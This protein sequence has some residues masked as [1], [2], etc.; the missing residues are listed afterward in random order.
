MKTATLQASETS[1]LSIIVLERGSAWPADLGKWRQSSSDVII[2]AQD[3]QEDAVS[4]ARRVQGRLVVLERDGKPVSRAVVAVSS[5][6]GAAELEA[7]A[8][9][10]RALARVLSSS[11]EPSLVF[12]SEATP[13]ADVRAE[14]MALIGTLLES[15]S[16]HL[17]IT[18][19]FSEPQPQRK[20]VSEPARP[21]ALRPTPAR[22]E[23][24]TEHSS[25]M[26]IRL[27]AHLARSVRSA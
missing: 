5:T 19:R 2:C 22:D 3:P 8:G 1:A 20:R 7:R 6:A 18:V 15:G 17:P 25:V 26:R 21:A 24:P 10:A 13:S 14:L 16:P 9:I 11:K 23:E 4:F 12:Q 27:P